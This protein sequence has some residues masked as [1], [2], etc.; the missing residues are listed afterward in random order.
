MFSKETMDEIE[1]VAQEE[2]LDPAALLAIAEVE[3]GGRAFAYVGGRKEPLI[4]FEGHYFDRLLN[5]ENR[6]NARNAGLSSPKARQIKKPRSQA[7]RWRLLDKAS[8]IDR[9]A[10]LQSVSWGMGQVMGSHYKTLGYASV[11]DLV[12]EA[13][14]SIAGQMRLMVRFI[15][16]NDLVHFIEQRDWAGF[17]RRYNGPAYKKNSYDTRIAAAYARHSNGKLKRSITERLGLAGKNRYLRAFQTDNQTGE[18]KALQGMLTAAGYGVQIDGVFGVETDRALRQ[19]Q[20][21]QKLAVDGVFGPKSK[22]ALKS[23]LPH[24]G[25]FSSLLGLLWRIFKSIRSI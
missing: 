10:A 23:A 2:G 17:A 3:S 24:L 15:R 21:V 11:D 4:R 7:D 9:S 6:K 12:Q 16:K 14:G 5:D 25:R 8:Q 20:T 1:Q 22:A 18:V 19:F 13:R